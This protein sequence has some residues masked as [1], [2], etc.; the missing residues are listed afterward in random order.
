[1]ESCW[2]MKYRWVMSFC[3]SNSAT[4]HPHVQVPPSVDVVSSKHP[5]RLAHFK[6][7]KSQCTISNTTAKHPNLIPKKNAVTPFAFTQPILPTQPNQTN[8]PNR[9]F[10]T[11]LPPTPLI[12]PNSPK[13]AT[14]PPS[15][16]SPI[17]KSQRQLAI[18]SARFAPTPFSS[19]I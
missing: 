7:T 2:R 12:R 16:S 3:T 5:K 6:C 1:V 15:A 17:S 18:A 13:L 19:L 11:I 10:S 9:I 4:Y 14:R 8:N